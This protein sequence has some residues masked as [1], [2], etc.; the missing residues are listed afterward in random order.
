M[1]AG[2]SIICLC[3]KYLCISKIDSLIRNSSS[4]LE[5]TLEILLIN[6]VAIFKC[7]SIKENISGDSISGYCG[8]H[9]QTEQT[10]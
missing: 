5:F 10:F 6:A 1:T 2:L 7:I 8:K 3:H 9:I 4:Q